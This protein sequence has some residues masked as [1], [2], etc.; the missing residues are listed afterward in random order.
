MRCSRATH[1]ERAGDQARHS[2][3]LEEKVGPETK[4]RRV[5]V[6]CGCK[7]TGEDG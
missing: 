3:P 7:E 4:V 5:L 6:P 1:N 2:K